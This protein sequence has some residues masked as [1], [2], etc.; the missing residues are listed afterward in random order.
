M[1]AGVRV[2]MQ[3][4]ASTKVDGFKYLDSTITFTRVDKKTGRMEWVKT[5]VRG[6][7]RRRVRAKDLHSGGETATMQKFPHISC[8]KQII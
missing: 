2:T 8:M 7:R 6:D 3:K 4:E 5:N 1:K